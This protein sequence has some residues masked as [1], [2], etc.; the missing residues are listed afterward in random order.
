MKTRTK[1]SWVDFTINFWEGCTKVS[2]GCQHCY[3][4]ARDN[5]YAEGRHWGPGAPRRKSVSAMRDLA[6]INRRFG[7]EGD[8]T[9]VE[10]KTTH[11]RWI[12]GK[13]PA[14]A[15]CMSNDMLDI[16]ACKIVKPQVFSLSLGDILDPEVPDAWLGEALAMIGQARNCEFLLLTK[17]PELWSNRITDAAKWACNNGSKATVEAVERFLT[18]EHPHVAWGATVENSATATRIGH[19]ARIPAARR[20]I[21]CEP[22]LG[23]PGISPHL[24]ATAGIAKIDLVI[25]GGE[26]GPMARPMHPVWLDRI[27]RACSIHGVPHHFKQ[28][29]TWA[30]ADMVELDDNQRNPGNRQWVTIQGRCHASAPAPEDCPAVAMHRTRGKIAILPQDQPRLVFKP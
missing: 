5:R 24:F 19:L 8:L 22:L 18:G 28:W 27:A 6:A 4:E 17:R 16:S 30:P 21:S 1:I 9:L 26:S 10:C 25:T 2:A 12:A 20:F 15:H 11:E 13:E 3:A 23:D 29:G 14:P 7:L